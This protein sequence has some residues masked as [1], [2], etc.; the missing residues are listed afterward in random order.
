VHQLDFDGDPVDFKTGVRYLHKQ[1]FSKLEAARFLRI[2]EIFDDSKF[3][4]V[5]IFEN[6]WTFI[7]EPFKKLKPD[8]QYLAEQLATIQALAQAG[9]LSRVRK[10]ACGRWY[11]AE[12]TDQKF[13]SAKCRQRRYVKSDAGREKRRLYM[14][15][16]RK[17]QKRLDAEALRTARS[18]GKMKKGEHFRL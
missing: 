6:E 1:G 5:P 16:F 12:R 9:L 14:R 3:S 13:H 10:C 4:L 18:Q 8:A 15:N 2:E 7:W 17:R 11:S